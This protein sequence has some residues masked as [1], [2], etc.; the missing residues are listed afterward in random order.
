MG[1]RGFAKAGEH[2]WE[3]PLGNRAWAQQEHAVIAGRRGGTLYGT[4]RKEASRFLSDGVALNDLSTNGWRS[5]RTPLSTL[6]VPRRAQGPSSLS[7][8]HPS[9]Y[10]TLQH[11]VARCSTLQ[12]GLLACLLKPKGRKVLAAHRIVSRRSRMAMGKVKELFASQHKV[13]LALKRAE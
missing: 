12:N 13:K 6:P 5:W 8:R 2:G 4:V 3:V 11:P 9:P 10:S 1:V 7:R